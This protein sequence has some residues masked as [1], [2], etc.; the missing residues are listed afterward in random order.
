MCFCMRLMKLTRQWATGKM[1][2]NRVIRKGFKFNPAIH[3]YDKCSIVPAASVECRPN[4]CRVDRAAS[5][6]LPASS[7]SG[8]FIRPLFPLAHP[9]LEPCATNSTQIHR[10]SS[11]SGSRVPIPTSP[12]FL[13]VQKRE[14]VSDS[15]PFS[16]SDAP[17]RADVVSVSLHTGLRK[18][19]LMKLVRLRK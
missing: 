2:R 13:T 5:V 11:I 12:C 16:R 15:G 4:I 3:V 10:A 1:I 7:S 18:E 17:L 9:Q 8:I 14:R 19:I 6:S